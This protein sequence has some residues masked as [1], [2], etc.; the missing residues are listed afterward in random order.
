[1]WVPFDE[2]VVLRSPAGFDVDDVF[3]REGDRRFLRDIMA[4]DSDATVEGDIVL[5]RTGAEICDPPPRAG[6]VSLDC[7]GEIGPRFDWRPPG[8][9]MVVDMDGAPLSFGFPVQ[10]EQCREVQRWNVWRVASADRL[11]YVDSFLTINDCV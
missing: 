5:E 2:S 1:M 7:S 6:G 9:E 11:E 8:V 3:V 4:I 10:P